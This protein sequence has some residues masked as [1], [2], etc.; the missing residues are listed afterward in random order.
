MCFIFEKLCYVVNNSKKK[1]EYKYIV[2][3]YKKLIMGMT[4][5][6]HP[7]LTVLKLRLKSLLVIGLSAKRAIVLEQTKIVPG[8]T[9]HN[10]IGYMGRIKIY[11]SIGLPAT[12]YSSI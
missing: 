3:Y 5:S 12:I 10:Y 1:A 4:S 2:Q 8:C 6:F 7:L 9:Q 11:T